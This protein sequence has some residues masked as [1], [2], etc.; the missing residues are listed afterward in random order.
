[1]QRFEV[2]FFY[3][4]FWWPHP[5][6]REAGLFWVKL[7][8]GCQYRYRCPHGKTFELSKCGRFLLNTDCATC[9]HQPLNYTNELLTGEIVL[10]IA[11]EIWLLPGGPAASVEVDDEPGCDIKQDMAWQMRLRVQYLQRDLTCYLTAIDLANSY[12]AL[13]ACLMRGWREA[14]LDSID[15]LAAAAT[16]LPGVMAAGAYHWLPMEIRQLTKELYPDRCPQRGGAEHIY[17][18]GR[19]IECATIEHPKNVAE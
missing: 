19:C 2:V 14:F 11:R 13:K 12:E 7:A 8:I 9:V 18:D 16:A 5:Y 1:M 6:A 15:R 3:K 17:V 10:S 4:R